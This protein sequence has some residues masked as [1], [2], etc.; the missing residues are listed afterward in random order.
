MLGYVFIMF[1]MLFLTTVLGT[2]TGIGL[3]VVLELALEFA[4]ALVQIVAADTSQISHI[5][6]LIHISLRF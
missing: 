4:L 1:S 2:C 3:S 5:N 6:R